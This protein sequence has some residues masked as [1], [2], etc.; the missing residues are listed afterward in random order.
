MSKI[1]SISAELTERL[2]WLVCLGNI[3]SS[4]K[5]NKNDQFHTIIKKAETQNSWFTEKNIYTSIH[6]WQCNLKIENLNTWISNYK[7]TKMQPVKVG[8]VMAGNPGTLNRLNKC[9]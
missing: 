8:I 1:K 5:K 4:Y 2:N 6:Y 7:I 3:F 9:Q